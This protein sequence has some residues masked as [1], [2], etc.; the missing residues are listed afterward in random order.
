MKVLA[1]TT[2]N[3]FKT[4]RPLS[5]KS[6]N[7]KTVFSRHP[8]GH[9]YE[10]YV[11]RRGSKHFFA[12]KGET[13]RHGMT[14]PESLTHM[15]CKTVLAE[16][17]NDYLETV[18]ELTFRGRPSARIPITLTSSALEYRIEDAGSTYVID[19]LCT[20]KQPGQSLLLSEACKWSGKIAFEFYHTSGLAAND[21]KCRHLQTLGIPVIQIDAREGKFLSID[22]DQLLNLDDGQAE[23]LIQAH[24]EKLR[25]TFKKRILGVLFNDPASAI[26][27]E[28]LAMSNEIKVLKKQKHENDQMLANNLSEYEAQKDVLANLKRNTDQYIFRL[29][30]LEHQLYQAEQKRMALEKEL[31]FVHRKSLNK[32]PRKIGLLTKLKKM[33]R[34]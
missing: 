3:G 23:T 18:L 5:A 6:Q 21:P 16:L 33:F 20:F 22:E 17:A 34:F 13:T 9:R 11:N 19:T 14:A 27:T 26:Y 8:A 30:D 10:M 4:I 32:S 15:L 25:N 31:D 29:N 28:A 2:Q 12:Y 24:I 7:L 1:Y